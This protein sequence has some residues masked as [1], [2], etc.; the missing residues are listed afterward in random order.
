MNLHRNESRFSVYKIVVGYSKLS[1]KNCT[2]MDVLK[3]NMKCLENLDLLA[4][5][6]ITLN[7]NW[8]H[9]GQWLPESYPKFWD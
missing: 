8:W 5:E 6:T 2:A 7:L 9:V 4:F 1:K 3:D